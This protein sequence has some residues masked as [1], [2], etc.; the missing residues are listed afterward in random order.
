ML[1]IARVDKPITVPRPHGTLKIATAARLSR[2][3]EF[4]LGCKGLL[5]ECGG[6]R[7]DQREFPCKRES[8]YHHHKCQVARFQDQAPNDRIL[9]VERAEIFIAVMLMVVLM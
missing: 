5:P 4:D 3:G 8:A 7:T 2:G 1:W 9:C 6:L